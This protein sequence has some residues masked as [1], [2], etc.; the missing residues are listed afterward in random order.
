L[1]TAVQCHSNVFK[2]SLGAIEEITAKLEMKPDAQP[3]FCKAHPVP[4]APQEAVDAE[5]HQLESKGFVEE[6]EFS[7]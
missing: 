7:E 6:V 4:Y 5:Y 2:P 3:K 1:P